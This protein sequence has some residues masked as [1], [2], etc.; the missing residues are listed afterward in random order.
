MRFSLRLCSFFPSLSFSFLSFSSHF[1]SFLSFFFSYSFPT[2]PSGRFLV[3]LA[4]LK[5]SGDRSRNKES[6]SRSL[7]LFHRRCRFYYFL[8]RVHGQDDV[9]WIS[10]KAC[11]K[12]KK[13]S[14]EIAALGLYIASPRRNCYFP[15][16]VY[17]ARALHSRHHAVLA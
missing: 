5:T 15:F 14:R 4:A 11:K 16:G 9:S 6:P 1:F 7:R 2:S 13:Y 17:L 12:K 10:V 8:M 3:L